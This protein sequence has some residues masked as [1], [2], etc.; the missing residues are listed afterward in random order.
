MLG[1][2]QA[3]PV[4]TL[5]L[6]NPQLYKRSGVSLWHRPHPPVPGAFSSLGSIPPSA[7]PFFPSTC[8]EGRWNG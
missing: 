5:L 2:T 3:R 8:P 7:P 4:F 6:G 1:P